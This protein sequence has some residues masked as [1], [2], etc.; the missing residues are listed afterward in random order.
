MTREENIKKVVVTILLLILIGATIN[1]LLSVA[2]YNFNRKYDRCIHECEMTGG[3]HGWYEPSTIFQ[4][5]ECWCQKT[6]EKP[7]RVR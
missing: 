3:T 6:G 5:A 7:Y 2:S 1:Y 4:R